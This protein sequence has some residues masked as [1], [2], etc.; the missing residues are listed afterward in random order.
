MSL[1]KS[2]NIEVGQEGRD[3]A[4]LEATVTDAGLSNVQLKLYGC[5]AFLR[6]GA[7]LRTQLEQMNLSEIPLLTAEG[8]MGQLLNELLLK[9]RGGWVYPYDEAELCHCR[10]VATCKVDAAIVHGAVSSEE[11]SRKTSAGTGCGTCRPDI[12]KIIEFRQ[13]LDKS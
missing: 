1:G 5:H 11:V 9:A 13:A 6:A 12:D 7:K 3:F 2:L 10:Q 4:R 8:H